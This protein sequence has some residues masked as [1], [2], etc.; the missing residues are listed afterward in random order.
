MPCHFWLAMD[1]S[2]ATEEELASTLCASWVD[3]VDEVSWIGPILHFEFSWIDRRYAGQHLLRSAFRVISERI[4]PEHSLLVLKAAPFGKSFR[5]LHRRR[6]AM[7]RYY[8]HL[9]GAKP[10]PGKPG[11]NGWLWISNPNANGVFP[12]PMNQPRRRRPVYD[13]GRRTLQ[14]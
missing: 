5:N 7:V 4:W 11:R 1:D 8:S 2:S 3:V 10:L 6:K 9:F 13:Y 12:V 14:R